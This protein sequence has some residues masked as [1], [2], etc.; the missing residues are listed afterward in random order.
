M[1]EKLLLQYARM[2]VLAG[3]NIQKGQTLIINA[4]IYAAD[5]VRLCAKTAYEAGAREVVVHYSDEQISR[6]KMEMTDLSV[7]CDVKPWQQNSYLQRA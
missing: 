4:P 1:D 7:L 3:V 2:A 5:L 6:I